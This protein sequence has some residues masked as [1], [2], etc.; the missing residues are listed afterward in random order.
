MTQN[1]EQANRVRAGQRNGNGSLFTER[2]WEELARRLMLSPQQ[3]EIVRCLINGLEDKEIAA[4]LRAKSDTGRHIK[5]T[6]VR[7]HINRIFD[8]FALHNRK[9]TALVAAVFRSFREDCF[10]K[11]CPRARL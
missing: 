3:L 4:A 5:T 9:R 6:T 2:E 8:K 7:E 11:G 10:L 1:D